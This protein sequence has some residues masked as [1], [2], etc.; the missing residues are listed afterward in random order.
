MI[1]HSKIS[2]SLRLKIIKK[3]RTFSQGLRKM[4]G[5]KFEGLGNNLKIRNRSVGLEKDFEA[6][7]HGLRKN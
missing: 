2:Q 6:T 1:K 5:Y 7:M 3:V 4:K